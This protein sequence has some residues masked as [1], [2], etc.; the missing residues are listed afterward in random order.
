M[1]ITIINLNNQIIQKLNPYINSTCETVSIFNPSIIQLNNK[2]FLSVR[3][4]A[5]KIS[6][7]ECQLIHDAVSQDIHDWSSVIDHTCFFLFDFRTRQVGDIC[8]VN[9]VGDVFFENCVDMRLFRGH[10]FQ[11]KTY[12]SDGNE[13]LIATYNRY[14]NRSVT[15]Y[16]SNI[17]VSTDN[18]GNIIFFIA[19]QNPICRNLLDIH[20]PVIGKIEK[21]WSPFILEN[22]ELYISQ[23]LQ[24]KERN[25]I[26]FKYDL[27]SMT[28]SSP[29]HVRS[30]IIINNNPK[31]HNSLGTVGIR[32]SDTHLLA[33]G[34]AKIKETDC[35]NNIFAYPPKRDRN[36]L[37]HHIETRRFRYFMYFYILEHNSKGNYKL[38]QVSAYFIPYTDNDYYRMIYFP[39]G[40]C[41][42]RIEKYF[43]L[44]YGIGDS[45]T[46]V[47]LF[48]FDMIDNLMGSYNPDQDQLV[49]LRS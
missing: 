9:R 36:Y 47:A 6:S 38:S 28:C 39:T 19:D 18:N 17:I 31:I 37:L 42:D 30:S 12:Y 40:L 26:Y 21:N 46:N 45:S 11:K 1:S 32:I 10:S 29:V 14:F 35:V 44:T 41:Y 16:I 8:F 24:D 5:N 22:G 27:E 43:Y 15:I 4:M 7:K 13:Y 23:W 3:V 20:N 49:I 33:V 2:G 34:H 25:H 48:T